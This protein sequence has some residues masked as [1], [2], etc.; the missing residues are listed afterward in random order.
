MSAKAPFWVWKHIYWGK[1]QT[2]NPVACLPR[3]T[4]GTE[5][6]ILHGISIGH[7]TI[8][9]LVCVREQAAINRWQLLFLWAVSGISPLCLKPPR[10]FAPSRPKNAEIMS[11]SGAHMFVHLNTLFLSLSPLFKFLW[12]GQGKTRYGEISVWVGLPCAVSC[13]KRPLHQLEV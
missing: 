11:V 13:Y 3:S 4:M 6:S 1:V 8:K 9:W 5:G 7:A 10:S 12:W 2:F